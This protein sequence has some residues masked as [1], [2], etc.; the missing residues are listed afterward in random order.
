MI[1][2]LRFWVTLL[3]ATF[4]YATWMVLGAL[5]RIRYRPGGMYDRIPRDYGRVMLRANRVPVTVTG[6]ERLD[7]EHGYVF[8]SNHLSWVDPWVLVTSL[9]GRVRFVAKRELSRVPIFGQ[10]LRAGRHIIIDRKHH[11]AAVEAYAQATDAIR[12]GFSA[13]IFAEGT[14][15][16]DGRLH[17]FKKGP[18]VLAIAAQVPVVPVVVGGTFP[19][20]PRGSAIFRPGPVSLTIAEPIPTTGLNYED[21]DSLC[22][23]CREAMLKLVRT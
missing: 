22:A 19:I 18:F 15:S 8:V 6:L 1:A 7:S 12:E 23:R 13:V 17:E 4:F 10:A 5:L 11:E 16:R 20:L 9:P 14:R 3:A 21:R 2:G